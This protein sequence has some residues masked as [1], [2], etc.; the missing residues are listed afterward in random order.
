MNFKHP[1]RLAILF[2]LGLIAVGCFGL[3]VCAYLNHLFPPSN[4]K[5]LFGGFMTPA[6]LFIFSIIIGLLCLAIC[7]LGLLI[8]AIVFAFRRIHP[9]QI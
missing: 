8:A 5:D 2:P 4:P 6:I 3:L 7:C 1:R 9:K